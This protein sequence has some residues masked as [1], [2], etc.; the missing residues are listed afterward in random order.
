MHVKCARKGMQLDIL[1]STQHTITIPPHMQTGKTII[2][3]LQICL[4]WM[5]VARNWILIKY[6]DWMR[7]AQH[8]VFLHKMSKCTLSFLTR[9][10]WMK[11][12]RIF[13]N[14]IK[15]PISMLCPPLDS[16]S[17]LFYLAKLTEIRSDKEWDG[18]LINEFWSKLRL[19]VH[20]WLENWTGYFPDDNNLFLFGQLSGHLGD[21]ENQ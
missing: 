9:I 18:L 7:F 20:Q 10:S 17:L 14:C 8:F 19:Q 2:I 13:N 11:P 16:S 6:L 5:N 1:L 21:D 4:N 12:V 15:F 3:C